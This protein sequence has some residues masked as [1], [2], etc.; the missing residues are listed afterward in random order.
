VTRFGEILPDDDHNRVL[1]SNVHP[2]DWVN[3]EPASRYHL[4]VIG[5]GTAG[6]ITAS[7]AAGLGAKVALVE[8]HLMGGDCLNVGCV[9]SKSLIAS[10]RV[11][12]DV[13]NAGRLGVD[14][15]EG[16]RADFGTVMARMREI[17]ARI[18]RHDSARRYSAD[19]GADVFL[20]E[21]RFT[22][23]RTV[24]VDGTVLRFR[25]AVIATGARAAAPPIP[26]LS[27]TRYLTNET[28]FELTE[29]PRRLAVI[30]AGPIGCEMAQVF[31]RLG[32]DVTLF[33]AAE[34]ILVREDADAAGI[35]QEGF[36]RDG[37]RLVL[38]AKIDRV[39]GSGETKSL[40]FRAGDDVP[41]KLE[42]DE[43]LVGVGRAPN[44]EGLGLDRVGVEYDPRAGVRVDDFLRTTNRR[45]YAA[46]DVCLAHKFT[47]TADATARLVVQNALFFGRKRLS[48]LVI[49]WCTYTDPEVAHVGLSEHEAAEKGI[50]ID[51]YKVSM[52]DVDRA[53]ADGEEEG[54]VKI[55]ARKGSD[56]I[57]GATI[58]ARH[59]GDLISQLSLAMASG[60][61][62][63]KINDVIYPYPTQAE[64]IK[65][66]AGA[67]VRTRLTP[68]VKR[69][70][71]LWFRLTR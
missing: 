52:A 53:L 2:P 61:G 23:P 9:P 17:R 69:V 1:L 5:A 62:L 42:V 13:R 31:R 64:S 22:G 30:G 49:P 54:F 12:G 56:R 63:S 15:P 59:S 71:D 4:V 45:I 41:Q 33:D 68:T 6:L 7:I 67:Y 19:I 37:V 32:T 70:F 38:G 16:S 3:P 24:E 28:V 40:H 11:L 26:G 60:I 39:E 35:V 50:A 47:H 65:R 55:H 58:V 44:V 27:D 46:G 57:L 10:S 48:S 36:R 18:S 29:Q 66:T 8:R 20:G 25:R 21:A 14:V 51:T 43:V 34:H